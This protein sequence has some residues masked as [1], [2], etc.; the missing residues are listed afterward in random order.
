[1]STGATLWSSPRTVPP[2]ASRWSRALPCIRDSQL[3]TG[4][5]TAVRASPPNSG[6]VPRATNGGAATRAHVCTHSPEPPNL[7][8]PHV[9]PY[10]ISGP[11][12]NPHSSLPSPGP[13]PTRP[14]ASTLLCTTR[15]PPEVAQEHREGQAGREAAEQIWRGGRE[16]GRAGPVGNAVSHLKQREQTRV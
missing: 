6:H 1:M 12:P 16:G 4:W 7:C 14:T 3:P 11:T 5:V 8:G 10:P 13:A 15:P 2:G 9:G